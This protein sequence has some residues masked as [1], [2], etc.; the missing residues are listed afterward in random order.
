MGFSGASV[1]SLGNTHGNIDCEFEAI[2]NQQQVI[3]TA[4]AA[5]MDFNN[6]KSAVI[7]L[8]RYGSGNRYGGRDIGSDDWMRFRTR[9][10]MNG[11]GS[12]LI[13]NDASREHG[14]CFVKDTYYSS[15]NVPGVSCSPAIR[16]H[17]SHKDGTS[18]DLLESGVDETGNLVPG[19]T[20]W[21]NKPAA[22]R[23]HKG[24]DDHIHIQFNKQI[25]V[26]T[27]LPS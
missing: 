3:Q 5:V 26:V 27:Y 15:Y 23:H 10:Y 16:D 17:A 6:G 7:P 20:S 1:P 8:S 25:L 19:L 22:I 24:H 11:A 12:T 18:V 4:Q 21:A 2:D 9:A 14:G 13:Y